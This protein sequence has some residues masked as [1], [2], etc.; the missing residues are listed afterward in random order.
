MKN[1]SK[2]TGF[3]LIEVLL[4]LV[5]FSLSIT[6]LANSYSNAVLA[7]DAN[8][9]YF[10]TSIYLTWV[11]NQIKKIEDKDKV[12][13]GGDFKLP[14]NTQIE[15]EA[16]VEETEVLDLFKVIANFQF[17]REGNPIETT[18]EFY[19]YKPDWSESSDRS[20]LLEK[21]KEYIKELEYERSR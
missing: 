2:K 3:S 16:E 4:A 14:N 11:E 9:S 10:N 21:K 5:I 7:R 6:I 12:E 20:Q 18:V 8:Q 19:T 13:S 15:W 17:E 1:N